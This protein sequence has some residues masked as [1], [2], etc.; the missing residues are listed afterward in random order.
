M[1][2]DYFAGRGFPWEYDPGPPR[3]RKWPRLF[4]E[5]PNYRALGKAVMSS[6][7]EKYRWH[8]GPL[9]YRGR[10]GD[11]QVKVLVIGQEGGQDEALS[12]RAFTGSSGSRMQHFLDHIGINYSYLFL[13][14]FV[15]SIFNQYSG[16]RIRWLAQDPA[17]PIQQQRQRIF[18]YVLERNDVHLVIAVGTAAKES[19]VTWVASRGGSCPDGSQTIETC[20]AAV[21]GPRTKTLGVLH[22][23]GASSGNLPAIKADYQRAAAQV[24]QWANADPAWLPPDPGMTRASAAAYEYDKLPI[25][26]RDLPYG[27]VWRLGHQSTTSN[28]TDDQRGIQI[29]SQSA[30]RTDPLT[31]ADEA[32]GSKT[33]YADEPGDLP[34]EPPVASYGDFDRG[35][36][37]A[38]A[39]LLSGGRTGFEWPDWSALGVTTHPSFGHGP[40]YRGR[41]DEATVIV[42]ADQQSQDDLFTCRALTGEAGQRFHGFLEAIGV[43]HSYVIYRVL[44]VDTLDLSTS[45]RNAI[46]DDAQVRKVYAEM[47]RRAATA[48]RRRKVLLA[49]GPMAQRLAAHVNPTG[50]DVVELKAWRQSSAAASWHA[51]IATLDTMTFGKDRSHPSFSWDGARRQIP[52]YDLPYGLPRW[53]GSSGDRGR[54]PEQNSQPSPHFRMIFMPEWAFSLE[55]EPLTQAEQQA[56]AAAP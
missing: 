27:I 44:P 50:L 29:F 7:K 26:F 41:P 52:R 16:T 14:T 42:L 40:I 21:L 13:N 10:L 24:E 31:Y 23:G 46:V 33:G 36:S 3:N 28:R 11:D 47:V 5:T 34:Y 6:G 38:T 2:D 54:Q 56:A 43:D 18:E 32:P 51:A 17:S 48:S 45:A 8:F 4:S 55:P 12:R 39:R 19:V 53:Q 22:P 37:A 9:Y 25:P 20:D 15:Y 1:A 49:M 30:N 35:P